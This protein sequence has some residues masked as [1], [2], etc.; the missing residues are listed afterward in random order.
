MYRDF[1]SF[2]EPA[3]GLPFTTGDPVP[4]N[5][6]SLLFPPR[7]TEETHGIHQGTETDPLE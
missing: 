7:R 6:Q 1:A 2:H 4:M 5:V 3:V